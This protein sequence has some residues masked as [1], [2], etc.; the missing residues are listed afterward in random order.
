MLLIIVLV[1]LLLYLYYCIIAIIVIPRPSRKATTFK[2][3]AK[4][5]YLMTNS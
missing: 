3:Q 5:A 1:V 4:V 2:V